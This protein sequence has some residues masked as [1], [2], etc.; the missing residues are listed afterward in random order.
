MSRA[1]RIGVVGATGA[2][3]AEVMTVLDGSR[4][5]VAGIL[6]I[7]T[8]R[9]VGEHVAFQGEVFPVEMDASLRGLD[10]V[11]CCA[12][13]PAS[14]EWVRLALKA[15]VPCID[16]SGALAL[17]PEVPLCLGGE[18]DAAVAGAPL[19]ASPSGSALALARV[20]AP[21]QRAA[22]LV[23]L[24]AT[25]LESSAAG[26]REGIAALGAESIAL[27]NQQDAPDASA[28]GR[29]LAFDCHP[30]LGEVGEGGSTAVEALLVR[31]LARL[32]GA[33]LPVAATVALIPTFIGM[34]ASLSI[35]LKAPLDARAAREVLAAA[36]GLELWTHDA[37]GPNLR[38]A[39]SRSEVLVGRLRDD[40]TRERGLLLWLAA[41]PLRI[42]AANAVALAELRLGPG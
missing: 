12:P 2:L 27:F 41:D 1:V 23:R 15:E 20:L 24:G 16:C 14:L 37:E 4:L 5:R 9:S 3:G 38:A 10:L 28:A 18:A 39:A 32:L 35:E 40:P 17:S 33:D 36:P 13:A 11:L 6:P 29:R 7:A 22:G 30:A 42:A 26:G 21:L 19:L 34:A 31:S 8:Q 25:L